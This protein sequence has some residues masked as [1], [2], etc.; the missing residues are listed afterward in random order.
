MPDRDTLIHN[1]FVIL[2]AVTAMLC[3]IGDS[4]FKMLGWTR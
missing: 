3:V 1:L 4:I 2:C